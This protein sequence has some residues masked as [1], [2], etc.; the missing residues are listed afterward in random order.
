MTKL[1]NRMDPT[2]VPS[3]NICKNL[4]RLFILEPPRV[5]AYHTIPHF[6]ISACVD[7]AFASKCSAMTNRFLLCTAALA[8]GIFA[9][10]PA[11]TAQ[12][13][14]AAVIH[15]P[16]PDK[17]FPAKMEVPDIPSH[18]A[19]LYAL[20]YIAAGQGPHPTVLL[21]H[22]FPG[23][24]QNMDLAQSMRR[25]GWN[26]AVPH[27]RGSWGSSGAFSFSNA[28]EDTQAALDF[29]RD[30]ENAKKYGVDTKKIVLI[31]HSMGGFM[32]AYTG[33]HNP[34][35]YAVGL[36]SAWNIGASFAREPQVASNAEFRADA[37]RLA[38]TTPEALGA[39][40]GRNIHQWNFLDYA[41]AL[42]DHP[43]LVVESD[44]GLTADDKSMADALRKSGDTRVA[45][46]HIAT[47][48]A[49]SDHRIALQ[50]VVVQWLNSLNTK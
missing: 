10:A 37:S 1:K 30:P 12:E 47:D 3:A 20:I 26:V 23:N 16:A 11:N 5:S 43:I 48:H 22:G 32:V 19:R 8:F 42:K 40:A 2:Q 50:S 33:A 49:Y 36:I 7:G 38:G 21:M 31:G 27:Y 18:G 6:I 13:S 34:D 14:P 41:P 28:I 35:V 25:A 44:D 45:E 17:A 15:D 46:Q 9:Y 4:K 29:L 24:E 39:E